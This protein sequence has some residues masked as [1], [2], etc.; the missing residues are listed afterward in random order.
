[1]DIYVKDFV[2]PGEGDAAQGIM[3][4]L[5]AAKEKGA[6]RV[7]F[8]PGTYY[9][10]SVVYTDT[11]DNE[12]DNGALQLKEKDVHILVEDFEDI[13]LQGALSPEGEIQTVLVG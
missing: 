10:K 5:Q 3:A 4:A 8:E 9:M 11:G 7:V 12:W 1:M 2:R 13:T 6:D